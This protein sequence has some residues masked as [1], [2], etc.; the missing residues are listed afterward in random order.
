MFSNYIKVIIRNTC[1][2]KTYTLINVIGL[3][4]GLATCIFIFLWVENELSYDRFHKNAE[5]IYRVTTDQ[6]AADGSTLSQFAK[7]PLPFA[8]AL[9][10]QYPDVKTV[11]FFPLYNIVPLVRANDKVFYED[12]LFFVDST[13]FEVFSFTLLRGNPEIALQN[14]HSIILT[15]KTA[16]KYFG[17]LDPIGKTITIENKLVYTITGV[18]KDIPFN[19]HIKFDFLV[20]MA[21]MR[22]VFEVVGTPVTWLESWYW[23]A[24]YTYIML[25]DS[26]NSAAIIRQMPDFVNKFYPE[27]IK[28]NRSHSLQALTDIHLGSHIEA[29]LEHNGERIYIFIFSIAALLALMIAGTNYVNISTV[30]AINRNS[31]VGLRKVFGGTP[32]QLV[33]QYLTES[34]VK[35]YLSLLLALFLLEASLPFLN[36]ILKT[37]VSLMELFDWRRSAGLLLT[38]FLIGIL[39][40]IYPALVILKVEPNKI[41]RGKSCFTGKPSRLKYILT[42][43]QFTISVVLSICALLVHQQITYMEHKDPGFT[44]DQVVQIGLQGTD[45]LQHRE[46][47]KDQ[48][49]KYPGISSVAY[50]SATPGIGNTISVVPYDIPGESNE[51]KDIPSIFIDPDFLETFGCKLTKG[52]FFMKDRPADV[53]KT[54][55]LNEKAVE[56]LGLQNPIGQPFRFHGVDSIGTVIGVIKNFNY[57]SAHHEIGPLVLAVVPSWI[58]RVFVR[59]NP[60]LTSEALKNINK[61][62][63]DYVPDHPAVITFLDDDLR[64]L[65]G[66]EATVNK[67]VNLFALMAISIAA[68]GLFGLASFSAEQRT[69]EIGIRKV[70][71][72]T[73]SNILLIFVREFLG[74]I[75]MSCVIAFPISYLVTSLW[76]RNFAFH[77]D[78]GF[79]TYLIVGFF[80]VLVAL[81]SIS[82]QVLKAAYKNP[83]EAL[84][85]E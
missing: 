33:T 52:R 76:L 49:L 22:K 37:N 17:S 70:H 59:I 62:W 11:R 77:T 24:C 30:G 68:L 63:R 10:S 54:F 58:D 51:R 40:G 38:T 26:S 65:Y 6:R 18:L 39:T 69:K 67:I 47:F 81:S 80:T 12:G 75:L 31:E 46:S 61:N 53:M 29:E 60:A 83:I 72:A 4:L 45:I 41:L 32:R 71:G 73:A 79:V 27:R 23:G 57:E 78:I 14:P 44:R 21:D 48:L 8:E 82:V 28:M 50:A 13:F 55:V 9:K 20:K 36:D 85:H 42:V 1:K 3:A 64:S 43:G 74:V 84:H 7:V 2:H 56:V 66:F 34:I 5:C 16:E 25:P 15:E 19:S 35:V